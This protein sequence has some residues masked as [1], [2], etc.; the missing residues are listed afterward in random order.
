M[1]LIA[2]TA[3]LLS[4]I[5]R[6]GASD[7]RTF[8]VLSPE[9]AVL[10]SEVFELQADGRWTEADQKIAAIKDPVLM[11][12]VKMERLLH[13]TAYR[14]KYEELREWMAYYADHPDADKVYALALKRR[15]KSAS[16]PLAP[17]G[18]KWKTEN[19]TTLHPDLERDY[20]TTSR[21]RLTQI[22]GRVRHLA[23]K[24]QA[25]LALEEI[26]AHLKRGTITERQFDRM[27]SWV[28]ASLYYQ[29][30]QSR[31]RDIADSVISRNGQSAVL[32]YWISGL[33]HYRDGDISGAH[34]RFIAMA[35]VKEQDDAL[36]AAAGF[37][38]ARSAL[39]AGK[40]D[41][42]V[43]GLQIAADFPLTFYGQLALAQLGRQYAFNWAVATPSDDDFTQLT[44][45][46]PAVRRATALVEAGLINEGDLE[47]RWVNARIDDA[48]AGKLLAVE[49][50]LE[51]PAAQLDLALNYR[52]PD[53]EA[54]LFPL[55]AFEPENG[56][57]ADPALIYAL[58]RQESKFKVEATSRVGARGLLQLMPRTASYMAKDKSLQRGKGRDKLYDPALNLAIG[59]DYVNHLIETTAD[60]DLFDM[61]VAYNGGPGNLR[62]WKREVPIEDPLL[63]IESIPNPE[64]RDFV[65]KVLTNYWI[66][67]QRLGLTPVSRDRVA[68]GQLPL[69]DALDQISGAASASR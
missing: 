27:R 19:P 18:R 2:I 13:P 3:V 17:I 7:E 36:R 11:G 58:M 41:A 9:D 29:G 34:E 54:G 57:T 26:D 64:S 49:H 32:A 51:L 45:A 56:F 20:A 25:S 22:E 37:W 65:E 59:Q 4:M 8:R 6:A 53:F 10:Y 62:R 48:L 39:A 14:A 5:A 44:A 12:Y 47:F 38:A 28:A 60:G 24:E 66:Y 43:E 23:K 15:P 42:V 46:D 40:P 52:G 68:A 55:P 30:Y 35:R 1:R 69:Y 16:P 61:A 50:A 21:P 63:F 31:A 33:I 67:R